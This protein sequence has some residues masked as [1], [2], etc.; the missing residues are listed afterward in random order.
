MNKPILISHP[1]KAKMIAHRGLSGIETENTAAA[2]VAAGQH[3]YFGIE[4]DVHRTKDGRFIIIHDDDTCRVCGESRIVE[5]TD[6]DTLRTLHLKD[7][8][9]GLIRHDLVL[10]TLA[11]YIRILRH[12]EKHAVLEIKNPMEKADIESIIRII[13]EEEYLPCTTFISF[14]FQNM[15]HIRSLLP[16]Q[17]AQFLMEQWED[18][19][20]EKLAEHRLD[21]D[22]YF[23][24]LT[25][26]R[27]EKLHKKGVLVNVWTVD[28]EED[29]LALCDMGVDQITSNILL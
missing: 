21:L 2:F 9:T 26:E 22:I 11:E 14:D 10:P 18:S 29:A 6:F 28:K 4:T 23:K 17:S 19:L 25:K 27:V 3:P 15:L 7:K 8:A 5:E 13:R 16:H 20:P 12:Y 1:N 24:C